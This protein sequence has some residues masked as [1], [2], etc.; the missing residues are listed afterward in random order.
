[1]QAPHV[2]NRCSCGGKSTRWNCRRASPNPRGTKSVRGRRGNRAGPSRTG[3]SGALEPCGNAIH[4]APSRT[5]H[6]ILGS[7]PDTTQNHSF[8]SHW[9][10]GDVPNHHL[11]R[12]QTLRCE[13]KISAAPPDRPPGMSPGSRQWARYVHTGAGL[14]C[15]SQ[16]RLGRRAVS[17]FLAPLASG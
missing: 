16:H 12:D 17:T 9:P 3:A 8:S 14:G 4:L 6:T 13:T 11:R 2:D 10:P 15:P 5:D 1:M 7:L